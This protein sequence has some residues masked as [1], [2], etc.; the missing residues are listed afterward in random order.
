VLLDRPRIA[1]LTRAPY[2][3]YS[4]GEI[5]HLLDHSLGLR[6]AYIDNAELGGLDWR[7]YNVLVVPEG[8]GDSLKPHLDGLRAWVRAGGTLIAIGDSAGFFTTEPSG[9]G[10]ART[11][12]DVLTKLD[13]HALAVAREWEGRVGTPTPDAVWAFTTP[14]AVAFPWAEIKGDAKLS[15]DEAKRRDAWNAIFMPTGALLA[16]RADDRH[17]L[18][19][20]CG[21]VVPIM[22]SQGPVLMAAG[23]VQAPIRLG[24]YSPAPKSST[25]PEVKAIPEGEGKENDSNK[26]EKPTPP[27]RWSPVPAGQELRLR[28]AGLLWPHAADRL[29]DTAYVT[30][31]GVGAGQVILFADSPTFRGAA[32][33]TMRVFSNAAVYGP[34]M[35]ANQ[36]VPSRREE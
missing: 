6:A 20:G 7:R 25:P 32:K 16:G 21:E 13:E 2:G 1:V 8:A 9:L 17:W 11:L 30:R 24:A 15:D 19:V 23:N 10:S 4:F 5:W 35:G 31:E 18:T 36:P 26:R 29:A 22:R 34:G 14:A 33:G 12:P 27:A 28:M 3:V